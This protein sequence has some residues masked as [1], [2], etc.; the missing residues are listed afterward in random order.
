LSQDLDVQG[1]WQNPNQFTHLIQSEAVQIETAY[2]SLFDKSF[3]SNLKEFVKL[4]VIRNDLD[5][6][7]D[8]DVLNE[9]VGRIMPLMQPACVRTQ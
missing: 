1:V 2:M 3:A 6:N 7:E 5:E 8:A 4:L 9:R